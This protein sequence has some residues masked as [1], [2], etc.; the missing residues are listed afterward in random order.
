M[1]RLTLGDTG[2][3]VVHEIAD[4]ITLELFRIVRGDDMEQPG[5]VESFRSHYELGLP[6]RRAERRAA[7]IHMGLSTYRTV[8]Q[9]RGTAARFP[10]IGTHLAR[11]RLE[12][13]RGLNFADTGH[14][15]HV[16]V[17]GDP[18]MLASSV[19]DIEPVSS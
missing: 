9:A 10:R 15:G 6:P 14:P 3:L 12:A 19:V 16:T 5:L 17:W 4:G 11:L 18:L 8:S 2:Q 1:T 13:G 7:V